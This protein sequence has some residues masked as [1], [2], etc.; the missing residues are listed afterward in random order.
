MLTRKYEE[1]EYDDQNTISEELLQLSSE[2]ESC[3]SNNIIEYV[4]TY[5][6]PY[7]DSITL[8]SNDMISHLKTHSISPLSDYYP[9]KYPYIMDKYL[10]FLGETKSDHNDLCAA[11]FKYVQDKQDQERK[12]EAKQSK[13]CPFCDNILIDRYDLFR[14][15]QL[16]HRFNI[17]DPYNL[18]FV[19]EYLNLI[20]K[21]LNENI[22]VYCD[23]I[24]RDSSALRKHMRT[25][26]HY[27]IHPKNHTY[28]QFYI[29][30]Y[31][32]NNMSIIAKQDDIDDD[33][34]TLGG[35]WSDWNEDMN[36]T[37]QCLFCDKSTC[38]PEELLSSHLPQ[39]HNFDLIQLAFRNHLNFYDVIRLVNRIRSCSEKLSCCFCLSEPFETKSELP[40]H[41]EKCPCFVH[42]LEKQ[43]QDN[44]LEFLWKQD[45]DDTL[46]L[47]PTIQDDPLLRI[48]DL[49]VF[50]DDE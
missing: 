47:K 9:E 35:S 40:L 3:I 34:D 26:Q 43:Y 2:E 5:S 48:V 39:K 18:V 23:N 29:L 46:D 24:F 10:C 31:Q 8:S 20:H 37:T 45:C 41:I 12:H 32:P 30:T 42:L 27:K 7:C 22:C 6:C 14:H 17:G 21:K 1:H 38:T 50:T 25:K 15:M 36:E 11:M 28:D 49:C 4:H 33:Q 16:I 13:N 44:K 19:D